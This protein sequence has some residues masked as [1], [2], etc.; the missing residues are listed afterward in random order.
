[1]AGTVP[2]GYRTIVAT[3]ATVERNNDPNFVKYKY[4]AWLRNNGAASFSGP[5]LHLLA[6]DISHASNNPEAV[7]VTAELTRLSGNGNGA[8]IRCLW[9]GDVSRAV[10]YPLSGD[11]PQG[12]AVTITFVAERPAGYVPGASPNFRVAVYATS[13]LVAGEAIT[14]NGLLVHRLDYQEVTLDASVTQWQRAKVSIE[15]IASSAYGLR[16]KAGGATGELELVALDNPAL[17][18]PASA[19]RVSADAILLDGSVSMGKIASVLQSNNFVAGDGGQGWRIQKSGAAEFNSVTIRRQL[20]VASGSLAVPG[21]SNAP[22]G[23]SSNRYIS[24]GPGYRAVAVTGIPMSAWMGTTKT[25][26]AV[27]GMTGATVS[28]NG[29]ATGSELWGW[30]AT[31]APLTRWSGAQNVRII[32]EFWGDGISAVSAHTITWRLYEVS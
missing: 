2:I 9:E 17:G 7:Y 25:Y 32:F 16:V 29:S 1:M 19:F 20:S 30:T 26:I 28:T 14:S 31:V 5:S 24:D 21:W 8:L 27:A 22:T 10:D 4:S 12:K 23:V 13:N 15:N 11:L 6:S 3:N 18:P